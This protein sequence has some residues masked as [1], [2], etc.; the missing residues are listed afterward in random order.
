ME[1]VTGYLTIDEME[2]EIVSITRLLAQQGI[3]VVT[4]TYGGGCDW[5]QVTPDDRIDVSTPLLSEFIEHQEDLGI[6]RLGRSD[7]AFTSNDGIVQFLLCEASDIHCCTDDLK[8]F[9]CFC[10]HW[11]D[12]YPESYQQDSQLKRRRFLSG[13]E[14][15]S[16]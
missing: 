11:A 12:K 5:D 15:V 1:I 13:F 3:L 14:W 10:Q 16:F 7:L 2:E 8:L 6:F 9:N 4:I